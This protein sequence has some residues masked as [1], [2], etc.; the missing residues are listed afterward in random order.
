MNVRKLSAHYTQYVIDLRRE[1]HMYPEPG[2]EETRTS[3]RI[4]EELTKMGIPFDSIAGTGVM[5]EIKGSP[6]GKLVA[7]RADMDAL[8]LT[9]RSEVPYKSKNQGVMHAC[10]HDG[11]IAMLLGAAGILNDL[12]NEIKGTIRLLFQPA[13]EL[14][15]GAARMIDEGAAQGVDSIFA[16]HLWNNS[17]AGTVSVEEGPRLASCDQ[18]KIHVYG[19]GCHGAMPHQGVDTILA[20]SAIV[21]NL[22]SLASREISPLET[23]VLSIGRFNSGTG[24]NI[25]PGEAVLEG[26]V[27]CFNTEI[28]SS[29][30]D[31]IERITKNT[32]A[33]YRAEVRLEYIPDIPTTINDAKCSKIAMKS[34]KKIMN[35]KAL[36]NINKSTGSEDFSLFL[37]KVPGVIALL[38]SRN[39]KKAACYPHHHES[40][41]IDEDVLV[42]GAALYAQYA[43]D[44]LES[45]L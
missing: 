11:H 13:E 39:E 41:D 27:R 40:F 25:I 20:A 10:G 18:F 28:R 22:Q 1:F 2:W 9:E 45:D 33:A 30:P 5:T 8:R 38:G 26:T 21:V 42:A 16:I 12:K 19:K 3:A 15:K 35:G 36:I 14:A 43:L 31:I 29:L 7:L 17:D 24:F 32:A 23:V 34:V 37:E 6:G 4:K 44:F